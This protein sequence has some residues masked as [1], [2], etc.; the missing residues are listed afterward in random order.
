LQQ[1]RAPLRKNRSDLILIFFGYESVETR[2]RLD[3]R[4]IERC[5]GPIARMKMKVDTARRESASS[6]EDGRKSKT[7]QTRWNQR[8]RS[9]LAAS[10]EK[11]S[12]AAV[13]RI[14]ID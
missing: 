7:T 14:Q 3:Q 12:A 5:L 6:S 1:A 11:V 4:D 10:Q 13:C 8:R 2:L 9:P